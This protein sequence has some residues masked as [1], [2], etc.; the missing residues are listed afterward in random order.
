M[1]P[2]RGVPLSLC[3]ASGAA[4]FHTL[5]EA[6]LGGFHALGFGQYGLGGTLELLRRLSEQLCALREFWL[7]VHTMMMLVGNLDPPQPS[8]RDLPVERGRRRAGSRGGEPNEDARLV[9]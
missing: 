1:S 6:H 8:R 4:L 5:T 9:T 3:G 2:D 7:V